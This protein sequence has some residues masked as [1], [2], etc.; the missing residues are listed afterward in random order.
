MATTAPT[1]G[2]SSTV[3]LV[4]GVPYRYVATPAANSTILLQWSADALNWIGFTDQ[5]TAR[6]IS[7]SVP[8]LAGFLRA[9]SFGS[10]GSFDATRDSASADGTTRVVMNATTA[11]EARANWASLQSALTETNSLTVTG[12]GAVYIN[13]TLLLPPGGEITIENGAELTLFADSNCNLIRTDAAGVVILSSQFVRA[14]GIVTVQEP[15]HPRR[16]G[17]QVLIENLASTSFNGLVTILTASDVAWTYISAGSAGAASGHG[18][19]QPANETLPAA[20]FSST[21]NLVTVTQTGHTKRCGQSV[22]VGN[23]ATNTTFNGNFEVVSVTSTTWTYTKAGA[24]TAPTGTAVILS[25]R[26]YRI[27]GPGKINGNEQNQT[28]ADSFRTTSAQRGI[29]IGNA[30]DVFL[31]EGLKGSNVWINWCWM[32]NVS[33]VL[34]DSVTAEGTHG[35][36]IHYEAPANRVVN[37]SIGG[38]CS[39]DIG[40]MTNIDTSIA[41]GLYIGLA[42]PSGP[43][44]FGTLVWEDIVPESSATPAVIKWCSA[45]GWNTKSIIV[46]RLGGSLSSAG[47]SGLAIVDDGADL[48]G[49]TL[50]YLELDGFSLTGGSASSRML[51]LTSTG[52]IKKIKFNNVIWDSAFLGSQMLFLNVAALQVDVLEMLSCKTN[53]LIGTGKDVILANGASTISRLK[54]VDCDWTGSAGT[55]NVITEQNSATISKIDLTNVTFDGVS[56][57]FRQNASGTTDTINCTNV[58]ATGCAV[59]FNTLGSMTINCLNCEF[60]STA[61][62][63]FQVAGGTV[64]II[65]KNLKTTSAAKTL[66]LNFGGSSISYNCLDR[67][68]GIDLG[69][70]AA[71]PPAGLVPLTGDIIYNTNATG[72]GQYGRTAAGAWAAL[73]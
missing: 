53:F 4:V 55:G 69:A 56:S 3:S 18:W 7:G 13:R 58:F 35:D 46:R 21:S 59:V 63:D 22:H 28:A 47:L 8:Q 20:S 16:V 26:G 64:R 32:F 17:Q 29:I 44:N 36:F 30:S 31:G 14:G 51:L 25:G 23:L 33:D 52:R 49:G 37:K 40:A 60:V 71:T 66:L 65:G 9:I 41:G 38:D 12:V 54:Q 6:A 43:G 57:P 73:F 11:A 50:D 24:D 72:T 27:T 1:S 42:S 39:D 62:N 15:G 61:N 67:E 68:A 5:P 2:W 70:S 45:T 48:T 10:A 19:V 34:T